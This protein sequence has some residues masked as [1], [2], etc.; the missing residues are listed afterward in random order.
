[1]ILDDAEIGLLAERN[2]HVAHC[3]SNSMKLAKGV[4]RVPD[5]LAA[6]VNVY[7]GGGQ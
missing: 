5:L 1:V 6:G 7:L 4:T 3:R 2:T